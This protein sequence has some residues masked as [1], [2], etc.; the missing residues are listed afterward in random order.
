MLGSVPTMILFLLTLMAYRILVHTPLRRILTERYARTQGAILKASEAI[1][2]AEA[3]TAEYEHRLRAARIAVFH[4]RQERL[5][6]IHIEA[7]HTLAET[8]M[9]AQQR[10]ANAVIAI[11]ES[12]QAARLQLD[13]F[14]DEL[15]AEALRAILPASSRMGQE[16]AG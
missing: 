14:I 10:M 7:E 16:Q 2:A 13:S 15:T 4:E 12:A 5:H 11:E 3:K 8:R 6:H 1:A 9:A